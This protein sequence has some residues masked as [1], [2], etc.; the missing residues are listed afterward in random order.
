[1]SKQNLKL[2]QFI[3]FAFT[4]LFGTLLHFLY[5]WTNESV[6]SAPF[7]AVNES[8]WE[9]MKL[10]FIPMFIFSIIENKYLKE[11]YS[12]FWKI[13]LRGI[14]LAL[15]MI[16]VI[17]YTYNGAFGK[18]PDPFNIAIFFI[19]AAVVYIYETRLFSEDIYCKNCTVPIITLCII[20]LLFVIFT[21][22]PPSLPLFSDPTNG[23]FGAII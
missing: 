23:T 20:A 11:K 3:G 6:W 14:L 18:S 12:R 13:K 16:P 10:I 4:S 21:F 17:Y 9:H 1:M 5:E 8:T 19:T 15:I 22:T 2:W 7:S